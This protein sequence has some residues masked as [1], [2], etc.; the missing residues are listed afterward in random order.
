M[1]GI[2]GSSSIIVIPAKAGI[3]GFKILLIMMKQFCVY[4]LCNKRNG[5]LYTGVTSNLLKRVYE[6]KNDLMDG[7]TKKYGIHHLVWYEIHETA[8]TAITREKQIKKWNRSWKLNLI[9]SFNPLWTDLY[10]ELTA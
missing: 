10:E 7:F 9:D 2:Y 5:T 8:E 4:I 3:Q 1:R 6:H